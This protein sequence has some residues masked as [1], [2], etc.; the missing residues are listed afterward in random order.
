MSS[1]NSFGGA[2][3]RLGVHTPTGGS[4]HGS[5]NSRNTSTAASRQ[6]SFD[7]SLPPR[8]GQLRGLSNINSNIQSALLIVQNNHMLTTTVGADAT[9]YDP[10]DVP[11]VVIRSGLPRQSAILAMLEEEGRN[12]GEE[13]PE[14]KR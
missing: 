14:E 3:S 5:H 7:L 11:A 9:S 2:L 8:G 6:N 4:G 12:E 10:V 13:D 1:L